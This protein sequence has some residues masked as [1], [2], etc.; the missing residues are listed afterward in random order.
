MQSVYLSTGKTLCRFCGE[1]VSINQLSVHIAKQHPRPVRT[2][3]SPTLVR[4]QRGESKR[5]PTT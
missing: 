1:S 5:L 3:M 2:D 4:R